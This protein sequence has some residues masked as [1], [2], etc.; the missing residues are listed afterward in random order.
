MFC[1]A[2]G[3][4]AEIELCSNEASFSISNVCDLHVYLT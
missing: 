1:F 2:Y 3:D 4:L